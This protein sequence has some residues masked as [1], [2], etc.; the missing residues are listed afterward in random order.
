MNKGILP[1]CLPGKEERHVGFPASRSGHSSLGIFILGTRNKSF[2]P[3]H[4]VPGPD[5]C[6]KMVK[7]NMA[8]KS[9][10]RLE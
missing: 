6:F 2:S 4:E 7:F 10:L 9:F 1:P 5:G 8:L 3:T